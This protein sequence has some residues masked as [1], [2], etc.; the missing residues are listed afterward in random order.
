MIETKRLRLRTMATEDFTDIH[1]IFTDE[2]VMAA[3][4]E[5]VFSKETMEWWMNNNFKHQEKYGYGLFSVIL[6]SESRII[7]DC[8]LEHDAFNGKPCVE[9]GYDFLSDYW[10]NG[11]ATEAAKAVLEY[12]LNDLKLEKNQICSFIRRSNQA[13]Q[14]V[15]EKVGMKRITAYESHGNAY[16]LYGFDQD[17]F[18]K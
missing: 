14:R 2:K 1:R 4:N 8:G 16:Y 7:G 11:Y 15:S 18:L 17:Y 12:A 13:S 10:N 9:I 3:F 6:K 5:D